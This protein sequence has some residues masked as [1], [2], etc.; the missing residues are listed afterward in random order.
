M[1]N[2]KETYL[3][4][5]IVALAIIVLAYTGYSVIGQGIMQK[6]KYIQTVPITGEDSPY[7]AVSTGSTGE[8]EVQ[9]ELS[10]HEPQGGRLAIDIAANTH[11]VDLSQFDLKEITALQIGTKQFRPIDAP[12]LSSHHASGTL[13]FDIGSAKTDAFIV[14]ITGIPKVATRSFR[15]DGT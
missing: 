12:T 4:Y 2:N 13:T 14:I 1:D 6:D 7:Q 11:S 10:P 3:L 15:W 5:G 9:I 8:G